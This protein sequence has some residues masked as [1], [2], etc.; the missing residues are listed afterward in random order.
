MQKQLQ[1]AYHILAMLSWQVA[2]PSVW[3]SPVHSLQYT[4]TVNYQWAMVPGRP[5]SLHSR[6][7]W[8]HL[9]YTSIVSHLLRIVA[10]L[11]ALR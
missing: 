4:G 9:E 11:S 3:Q 5:P 1:L 7:Q 10:M 6:D 2:R 8:G